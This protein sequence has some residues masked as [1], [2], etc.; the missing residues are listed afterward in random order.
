L[1]VIDHIFQD[2]K[3]RKKKEQN[4]YS[5]NNIQME[6]NQRINQKERESSSIS[7]VSKKKSRT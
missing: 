3:K 7:F 2:K 6:T 4:K 5:F 1:L